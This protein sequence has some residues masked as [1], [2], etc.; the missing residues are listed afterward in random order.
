M[1]SSTKL[2]IFNK[3]LLPFKK[4]ILIDADLFP[5]GGY[6]DTLFS[7]SVPAGCLEHR[8]LQISEL[9]VNS[10]SFDR[11]QMVQHGQLIQKSLTDIE[12]IYASDINA[13]LL[14]V[15]PNNDTFQSMIKQ[16]TTPLDEWFAEGKEHTGFWLGN[17]FYNFYFL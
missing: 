13:S 10:W 9:G 8:R 15:E 11:G 12:N 5:M 1:L 16:L 14:V 3:E 7:L 6:F 4:V 2:N 17:D